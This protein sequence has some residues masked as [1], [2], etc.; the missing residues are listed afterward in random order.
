M[1]EYVSATPEPA[2][3]PKARPS[4]VWFAV[5]GLLLVAAVV[6]GVVLFVRIFD[7]GFLTVEATVPADGA[8]HDVTVGTDGDRFLWEPEA[9]S[10]DCTVVDRGT[11]GPV[12]LQPVAGDFTREYDDGAW[13]AGATFDPGSGRLS[14]SCSADEG[15]A[16]IGP[17]LDVGGFV[18]S[19]IV[20]IAVPLLLGGLGLAV[21]IGT[22]LLWVARPAR[23]EP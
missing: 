10:A 6:V 17:A 18:S 1:T 22:G 13:R 11:G 8:A 14:V 21:L 23:Q 7:Q 19:V 4:A 5:G 20:A 12:S 9:G 16:Q 2:R 3:P 15:P